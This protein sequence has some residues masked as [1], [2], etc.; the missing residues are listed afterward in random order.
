VHVVVSVLQVRRCAAAPGTHLPSRR[1]LVVSAV[2]KA[3]VARKGE[4][5]HTAIALPCDVI[6]RT[7]VLVVVAGTLGRHV[8]PVDVIA[9]VHR[10]CHRTV[11]VALVIHSVAYLTSK[12]NHPGQL[13]LAISPGYVSRVPV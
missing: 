10:K 8:C 11:Q 9:R 6:I 3:G 12:H 2:Q 13:S 7:A 1:R 4:T 5:S